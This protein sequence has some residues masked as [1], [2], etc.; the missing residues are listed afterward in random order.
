VKLL[1]AEFI[2]S[3][4]DAEDLPRDCAPE[5]A[6]VGRSNVGKSSLINSLLHRKRLA[7]VSGTPGKTR[8]LNIIRV[9]TDA[10]GSKT[11]YLVDLP[12]YGYAK[13]AKSMRLEWGAMIERY[14]TDR[15]QL[16]GVLVLVD[17][18]RAELQDRGTLEWLRRLG[19]EPVVIVTKADKLTRGQRQ[20]RLKEIREALNVTQEELITYSSETHE[21][22]DEVWQAILRLVRCQE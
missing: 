16:R 5:V 7:K 11:L 17:I 18:R 15:D 6:I 21:G 1:S 19:R 22:R 12:G 8:L 3:C 10:P 13:V 2:K 4:T 20:G 14:L 9:T